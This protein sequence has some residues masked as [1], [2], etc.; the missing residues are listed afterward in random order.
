MDREWLLAKVAEVN[1]LMRPVP[2]KIYLDTFRMYLEKPIL[3]RLRARYLPA[4]AKWWSSYTLPKTA[5]RTIFLY[6]TRS[7]PHLAFVI[8]NACFYAPGWAFTIYCTSNNLAYVREVLGANAEHA[9]IVLIDA[10]ETYATNRDNYNVLL[11]SEK[12]W[13]DLLSLGFQTCLMTECDAYLRDFVPKEVDQFDYICSKYSW[14]AVSPGGGG[15]SIRRTQKM[16]DL[17]A[18]D[19]AIAL[20][21]P[22]QDGWIAEAIA[23]Y[24]GVTNNTL[25]FES[26]LCADPLGVHQWWTFIPQWELSESIDYYVAYMELKGGMFSEKI[27]AVF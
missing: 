26:C 16:L 11:K 23:K 14:D 24:G 25:F 21:H 1:E 9:H 19:P 3:D 15:L 5:D 4:L 12:F 22:H 7:D 6:E 27:E 13:S 8:Y 20:K 10:G 2:H 18:A 17:L